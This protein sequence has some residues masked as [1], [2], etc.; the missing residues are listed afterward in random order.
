[1]LE[2]KESI[3]RFQSVHSFEHPP[4]RIWERTFED[5]LVV[6]CA[7]EPSLAWYRSPV[8]PQCAVTFRIKLS[9]SLFRLLARPPPLSHL[10]WMVTVCDDQLGNYASL[11]CTKLTPVTLLGVLKLR[12][13]D[14]ALKL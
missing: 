13:D 1:M 5:A 14:P 4:P 6:E 8:Q 10:S 9:L 12:S 7:I 2:S 3:I 11:D